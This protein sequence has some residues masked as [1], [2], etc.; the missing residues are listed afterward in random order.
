MKKIGLIFP[1]Q[2]FKNN[3]LLKVVDTVYLIEDS[4]F[5]GDKHNHLSFH[6]M[7]IAFHRATM[8]SYKKFL[9]ATIKFVEARNK[10]IISLSN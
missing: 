8:K 10:R 4:L 3:P 1:H 5:F 9:E 7:K 6:K 2:L